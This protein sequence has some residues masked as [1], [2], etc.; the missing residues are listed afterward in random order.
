MKAISRL[1]VLSSIALLCLS[2]SALAQRTAPSAAPREPALAREQPPAHRFR[3]R[4]V[5]ARLATLQRLGATRVRSGEL[6]PSFSVT[7]LNAIV[8]GRGFLMTHDMYFE[9]E[10]DV[11]GY[12]L[13]I[14][15]ASSVF[16]QVENLNHKRVLVDCTVSNPSNIMMEFYVGLGDTPAGQASLQNGLVSFLTQPID[17]GALITLRPTAAT[18]WSQLHW[19]LTGCE[20]TPLPG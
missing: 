5:E 4:A 17:G 11:T 12:V 2:Q 16:I 19:Q 3:A 9:S 20:L 15:H 6:D 7:P 10:F 13:G 14:D 18:H 1:A 8:S